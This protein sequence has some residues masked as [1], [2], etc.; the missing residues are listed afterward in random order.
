[1][2]KVVVWVPAD[3]PQR[4]PGVDAPAV[5]LAL[6]EDALAGAQNGTPVVDVDPVATLVPALVVVAAPELRR[7]KPAGAEQP[8][9]RRDLAD[10]HACRHDHRGHTQTPHH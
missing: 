4:R 10:D 6:A 5:L 3:P 2:V 8:V 7:R 1:M 9:L